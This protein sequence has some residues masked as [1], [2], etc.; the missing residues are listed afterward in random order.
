MFLRFLLL[1]LLTQVFFAQSGG[2]TQMVTLPLSMA[3][4][5][6][7]GQGQSVIT[8]NQQSVIQPPI[9]QVRFR[10]DLCFNQA[11]AAAILR[12]FQVEDW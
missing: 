1:L 8:A 3:N 11:L 2:E 6:T 7:S 5:I 10:F 9:L 12:A 4:A